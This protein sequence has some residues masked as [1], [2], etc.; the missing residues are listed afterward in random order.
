[1]VEK[2]GFN[3][4]DCVPLGIYKLLQARKAATSRG[5]PLL[6]AYLIDWGAS[7]KVQAAARKT[8]SPEEIAAAELILNV[9]APGQRKAQDVMIEAMYRRA[10][11][12]LLNIANI[13]ADFMVIGWKK[14]FDIL[15]EKFEERAPA[16][17][18]PRAGW[19]GELGIFLQVSKELTPWHDVMAMLERADLEEIDKRVESGKL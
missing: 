13:D 16:L 8:M 7:E 1:M 15:I 10:D 5:N 19:Q 6:F 3:P 12:E 2:L 17:T 4:R 9:A 18:L 11:S 14:A